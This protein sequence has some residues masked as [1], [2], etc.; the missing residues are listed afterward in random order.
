VAEFFQ[1]MEKQI[2]MWKKFADLR[3]LARIFS[4]AGTKKKFEGTVA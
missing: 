4:T 1:N 3:R 2:V